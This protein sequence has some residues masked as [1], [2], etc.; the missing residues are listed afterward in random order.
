M[1]IHAPTL[2][3]SFC[4]GVLVMICVVPAPEIVVKFPRPDAPDR[5]YRA[6]DGSCFKVS[7][8]KVSCRTSAPVVPQPLE[9]PSVDGGAAVR[10]A[11]GVVFRAPWSS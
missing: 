9:D 10:R 6:P 3:I 4:A 5:E 1:G 7:A 2:A 8:R 11:G